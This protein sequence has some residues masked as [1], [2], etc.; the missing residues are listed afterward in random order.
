VSSRSTRP[1]AALAAGELHRYAAQRAHRC[2]EG[3]GSFR[4]GKRTLG[5]VHVNVAAIV[6]SRAEVN[7]RKVCFDSS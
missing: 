2:R 3:H 6:G 1:L 4:A 5:G 7:T